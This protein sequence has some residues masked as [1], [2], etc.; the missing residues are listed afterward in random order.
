MLLRRAAAAI[1]QPAASFLHRALSIASPLASPLRSLARTR[2][3]F[4]AARAL[5]MS[6]HAIADAS[7]VEA[8]LSERD[9]ALQADAVLDRMYGVLERIEGEGGVEMDVVLSVR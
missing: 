6:T 1:R 7:V 4:A 8:G 9:Y 5:A 3:S 2:G